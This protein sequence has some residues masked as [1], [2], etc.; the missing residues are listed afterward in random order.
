MLGLWYQRA[1]AD[2]KTR[3]G[4]R[5]RLGMEGSIRCSAQLTGRAQRFPSGEGSGWVRCRFR[6][7]KGWPGQMQTAL[8]LRYAGPN[9]LSAEG[10]PQ[11]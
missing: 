3:G 8:L 5:G 9:L 2:R 11:K 7:A 4:R 6:A 10:S 1:Q